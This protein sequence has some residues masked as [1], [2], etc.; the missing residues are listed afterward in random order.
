MWAK[1]SQRHMRGFT[2]M[3]TLVA[4]MILAALMAV[5]FIALFQQQKNLK[6]FELDKTAREIYIAAQNHLTMAKTQGLLATKSDRGMLVP[7]STNYYYYAV[8]GPTDSRLNDPDSILH[9]MLPY[10]SIDDTVRTGGSYVIAY[11]YAS[12][13]IEDVFYVDGS[14]LG[15][16]NPTSA[17]P[18]A[19]KNADYNL[20]FVDPDY[21]GST[22]KDLR[23]NYI[24]SASSDNIIIGWYNGDELADHN[25]LD[26][27]KPVLRVNNG[28]RLEVVLDSSWANDSVNQNSSASVRVCVEGAVSRSKRY[29]PNPLNSSS[30]SM[31]ITEFRQAAGLQDPTTPNPSYI[32]ILDD[33]TSMGKQFALAWAPD[34]VT[35]GVSGDALIPGEDLIIYAEVFSNELISSSAYS[36]PV[37]TNSLF[38]STYIDKS[39]NSSGEKVA[40]ISSIRHLENID[41]SISGYAVSQLDSSDSDGAAKCFKQASSTGKLSWYEFLNNINPNRPNQVSIYYLSGDKTE[42][43][44]YAP[45]NP[46]FSRNGSTNNYVY[47]LV[48]YDGSGQQIVNCDCSGS[49]PSGLFGIVESPADSSAGTLVRDLEL[50][51]FK[52]KSTGGTAGALAG[53]A[54]GATV[55]NVLVHNDVADDTA[56]TIEGADAVGGLIGS[57]SGGSISNSAASV[58][59]KATGSSASAGGLVGSV[60]GNAATIK[61]SYAGGHT[62]GNGQY[63]ESATATQR[64]HMNVYSTATAGGLVGTF[65]GTEIENCYSTCS[66]QGTTVGGLVGNATAGTI[67]KCYA[68]GLI[69]GSTTAGAF[70]GTLGSDSTLGTDN[71]Y[72]SIVN[73]TLDTIGSDGNN[74]TVTAFDESVTSFNAFATGGTALPYDATLKKNYNDKYPFKTA[75]ELFGKNHYGDWPA[76]ETLVVN[77]PTSSS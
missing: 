55:T 71:Q 59:V 77:T 48:R 56:Y 39:V 64:G 23:Q 29:L 40:R 45:V 26:L 50:K 38:A 13:S 18:N 12:A 24:G 2:L 6:Q 33:I 30:L 66:A 32:W 27:N 51:N 17:Y 46:R 49:S 16:S 28:D 61:N 21:R 7:S 37:R 25:P 57:M 34:S 73:S 11:D 62:D 67:G 72:Y 70:V 14:Q 47:Y 15:Q 10:G 68:T 5:G 8:C 60:D 58:Y 44:K 75:N 9:E 20:L 52:V 69:K 4:V 43:G 19:F 22:K 74:K 36:D 35:P 1:K 54:T 53:T 3:E 65:G 42:A 63:S 76:M 31:T 41:S